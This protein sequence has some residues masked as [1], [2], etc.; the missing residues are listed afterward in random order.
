MSVSFPESCVICDDAQLRGRIQFGENNIVHPKCTITCEDPAG[1]IVIGSGN[2]IEENVR[3]IN[4]S[5]L[6]GSLFEGVKMGNGCVMEI[7]ATVASGTQLGDYCVIG[8]KCSSAENQNIPDNTVIFGDS[9]ATRTQNA[10]I[11]SLESVHDRHLEYL[12][13]VSPPSFPAFD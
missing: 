8:A 12:R 5:G 1:E 2:I 11:R 4:R 6:F 13:E 3:I 7:R 10:H 9:H